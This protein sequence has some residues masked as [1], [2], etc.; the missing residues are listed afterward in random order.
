MG[1]LRNS[2]FI[3]LT[4]PCLVAVFALGAAYSYFWST[5]YEAEVEA[6]FVESRRA[7][8]DLFAKAVAEALWEFDASSA[9]RTLSGLDGILGFEYAV[10]HDPGGT[11]ADFQ[12]GDDIPAI[13]LEEI[14]ANQHLM[15][16]GRLF[17][18]SRIQHSE[19]GAI[20]E[21]VVV[22]KL[23]PM[24]QMKWEARRDAIVA[25]TIA[26]GLLGILQAVVA[27]SVTLPLA[28]ITDV[29]D[30]VAAGD[31]KARL[32]DINRAD[33]VGRLSRALEVFQKNASKLVE[34]KAEA[35]VNQ[36]IAE[37]ALVD[38]L[39]GLSNRRALET[40]FSEID[41]SI[42]PP[43]E[44]QY[45]LL[46]IDLDGFKQINDTL[47]HQAG[48]YVIQSAAG[49]LAQF[50]VE[51]EMVA[52]VGGD[53]FVLVLDQTSSSST[54]KELASDV[55]MALSE[56][57]SLDGQLIRVGASV[58]IASN[59]PN[60]EN[61]SV[62]LANADI[63]LYRAKAAGKGVAVE[64]DL[65]QRRRV[66]AKK[67][68]SDEIT[69]GIEAR[70]FEPFF[71]P[72]VDAQ[73]HKICSIE[74]LA[75]WRHPVE[76][77]LPPERFIGVATDLN[78][79]RHID[80]QVLDA[81]IDI[82][83]NLKEHGYH[84][85]RL[86]L[87]V[88]L[89]RLIEPEF[90]DTL[91][92]ASQK[93]IFVDLELLETTYLDDISSDVLWHL[94]RIRKMGSQLHIDDFGTGHSSIAGL[95]KVGPDKLKIDKQFVMPTLDEPRKLELV[96]IIIGIAE[97]LDI[98]VVAEGVETLEHARLMQELGAHYLQGYYFAKPIPFVEL[99]R[100]LEFPSAQ[101]DNI[102]VN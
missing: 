10:I 96:K 48:D 33:E 16:D 85:P 27:R 83:S 20:G 13:N 75:R 78:L 28:R 51:C 50:L 57:I 53:E 37:L 24:N 12:S 68:L 9:E 29:V 95:L 73:T 58:G 52:R 21:L 76:G 102:R 8:A 86:S 31:L 14:P 32:P 45:A 69:N 61:M 72:I 56:P 17:F 30:G 67:K 82:M 84:L 7:S 49:R 66:A 63:A 26:F 11:F 64:F 15:R 6:N 39:T 42:P 80:R 100:R 4:I 62:T 1:K 40:R 18:V 47:G 46:H 19:H 54:V 92:A 60:R 81:A 94:D 97:I 87:N 59:S 3:R 22:F 93:K 98:E 2:L 91:V 99:E 5:K 44:E 38:D 43:Y 79:M 89:M 70:E 23:A 55:I 88:S 90:F 35:E 71:Q 101:R 77:V 65:S 25:A 74:L 36:R 41:R 34:V